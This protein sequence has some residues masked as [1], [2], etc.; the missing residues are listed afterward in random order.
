MEHEVVTVLRKEN[1]GWWYGFTSFAEQ[2][3]WFP[4]SYVIEQQQQL[5][6]RIEKADTS[7]ELLAESDQELPPPPEFLSNVLCLLLFNYCFQIPFAL[8]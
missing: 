1:N 2:A 8:L 3:G 4:S 6:R 5:Q 7:K